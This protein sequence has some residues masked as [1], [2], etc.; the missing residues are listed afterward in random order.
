MPDPLASPSSA[1]TEKL[2]LV[3]CAHCWAAFTMMFSHWLVVMTPGMVMKLP[4]RLLVM[5]PPL[6]IATTVPSGMKLRLISWGFGQALP[7]TA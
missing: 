6:P 5:L 3:C 1:I 2:M 7:L 4:S